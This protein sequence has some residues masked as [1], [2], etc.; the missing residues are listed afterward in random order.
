M[1]SQPLIILVD[2]ENDFLEIATMKLQSKG[3]ETIATTSGHEA[4]AKAE[5]L[6]PD[7]VLSDIHMVPGPNGWEIA[8]ELRRNPKTRDI[9]IAFFTSLRD[10]WTEV[11]PELQDAFAAGLW[12]DILFLSKVDDVEV[13]G[14]RVMKLLHGE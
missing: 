14:E 8:L 9:K 3:F 2:D 12:R 4:I 11:P 13:L 1:R 7:L 6:Q 5:E 10:P